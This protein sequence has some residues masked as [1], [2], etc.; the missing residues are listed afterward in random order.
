MN[1]KIQNVALIGAGAVG[2]YFI[3]G[4]NGKKDINFSIIAEGE[5]KER[6]EQGLVINGEKYTPQVLTPKEAGVVDLIMI[7]I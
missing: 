3:W 5:R 7:A 2:G 6:L 4:L 1:L